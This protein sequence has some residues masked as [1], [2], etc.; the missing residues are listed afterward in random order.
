MISQLTGLLIENNVT[1]VVLDVGGVG[2]GVLIPLSTQDALPGTGSR[3]TLYTSLVVREDDMRLYGFATKEER[4]LFTLLTE[5]VSGIGPKLALNVLS[6]MS[7]SSFAGAVESGDLKSLGKISGVGKRTAERMVVE[8][9]DKVRVF[10]G[11]SSGSEGSSIGSVSGGSGLPV[12][13]QDAIL[14][15]ETLGF[16]RDQAEKAVQRVLSE[17]GDSGST[18]ENLIRR[19]LGLLNS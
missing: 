6:A 7:V 14:A 18:T 10:G 13:A 11:S 4:R 2:Y 16:K 15:L 8:L 19:A 12:E 5:S 17:C 3:V 9:R 1:D